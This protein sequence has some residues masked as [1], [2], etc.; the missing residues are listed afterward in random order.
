[1]TKSKKMTLEQMDHFLRHIEIHVN[2]FRQGCFTK[3]SD[4][5]SKLKTAQ[6]LAL[7][8]SHDIIHVMRTKQFKGYENADFCYDVSLPADIKHHHFR[9]FDAS[10]FRVGC[11]LKATIDLG[12]I[13]EHL[14]VLS[15]EDAEQQM[16]ELGWAI[17]DAGVFIKMLEEYFNKPQ[18]A[19]KKMSLE[20]MDHFLRHMKMHANELENESFSKDTGYLEKLKF[21]QYKAKDV[22]HD[23]FH[24][25]REKGFEGYKDNDFNPYIPLP[26]DYKQH[27]FR[28]FDY[29]S[30]RIAINVKYLMTL[31]MVME[32]DIPLEEA[33][34]R[35]QM[36]VLYMALE[37]AEVFIKMLE[38]Y[39]AQYEQ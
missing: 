27:S 5:L 24:V 1:M 10:S 3:G 19:Y 13:P 14:I 25:M 28:I 32:R 15:V 20:Q 33:V 38:E 9:H 30:F 37:D 11:K 7:D 31:G 29:D 21:A 26:D 6:K 16:N 2:E 34:G 8:V 36:K 23:L 35:Q 12:L 22:A 39:F 18:T 17:Q 4:Y